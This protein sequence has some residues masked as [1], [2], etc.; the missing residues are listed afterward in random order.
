[1]LDFTS[2]WK[3]QNDFRRELSAPFAYQ[4]DSFFVGPHRYNMRDDGPWHNAWADVLNLLD[5][6]FVD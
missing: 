2:W 3:P 4:L 6:E 5:E 1:M